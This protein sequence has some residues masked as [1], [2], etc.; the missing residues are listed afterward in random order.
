MDRSSAPP[1]PP[2]G[3][4]SKVQIA[5]VQQ[6][7]SV[8][9][10]STVAVRGDTDFQYC[11]CSQNELE[12]NK[13]NFKPTTGNQVVLKVPPQGVFH[14]VLKSNGNVCNATITSVVAGPPANNVP[15]PEVKEGGSRKTISI[16]IWV[17]VLIAVIFL[18][19]KGK[20]R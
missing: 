16:L 7:V 9:P 8:L 13:I 1:S 14:L 10:G 3:L 5:P 11:L 12:E 18:V 6:I 19:A 20:R 17:A 4:V 15:A 2:S